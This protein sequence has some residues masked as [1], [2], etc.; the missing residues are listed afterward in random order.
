MK[1]IFAYSILFLAILL[2]CKSVEGK[3]NEGYDLD[4]DAPIRIG[5]KNRI[6][7]KDCKV[8]TV[9]GD[10]IEVHYV[11]TLYKNGKEFD[12]SIARDSALNFHLGR[13]EVIPGWERG[14]QNMCIG[15]KRKLTIPSEL[16]YGEVG[17]PP[18]I[19]PGATLVFEIELVDILKPSGEDDDDE[20]YER[21]HFTE[22]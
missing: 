4:S 19:H 9:K 15:E 3:Q 5:V 18:D 1:S 16:A 6:K 7:D 11:G 21:S 12:S 13:S 2:C 22:F 14:L 8:K 17:A 20:Y 10:R